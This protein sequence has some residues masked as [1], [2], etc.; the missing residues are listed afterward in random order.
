MNVVLLSS[1]EEDMEEHGAYIKPVIMFKSQRID[2][3]NK[4]TNNLTS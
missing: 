2:A 3:S 1:E 4:P